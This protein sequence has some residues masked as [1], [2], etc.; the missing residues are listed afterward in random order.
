MS[1]APTRNNQR[2]ATDNSRNENRVIEE[3]CYELKKDV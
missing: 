2:Q 3:E 1:A